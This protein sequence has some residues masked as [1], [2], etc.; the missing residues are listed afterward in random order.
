MDPA[1]AVAIVAAIGIVV[2]EVGRRYER[3]H[4]R[5]ISRADRLYAQRLTLYIDAT[6]GFELIRLHVA[7]THPVSDVLPPSS[8][9]PMSDDEAASLY[10]RLYVG[11]SPEVIAATEEA[12]NRMLLDF[13]RAVMD[14][15][16]VR[17]AA[18]GEQMMDART[19]MED[20]RKRFHDSVDAL[21]A[22]MRADLDSLG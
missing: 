15:E 19:K 20:A 17:G 3:R 8:S 9:E 6:R 21:E 14:F 16:G 11:A 7:R 10:A 18:A 1:W 13:R 12:L 5:Q 2:P 4:Q 22:A